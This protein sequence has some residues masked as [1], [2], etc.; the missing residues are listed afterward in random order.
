MSDVYVIK[1]GDSD[2]DV[3]I[4]SCV[5]QPAG[6]GY[7]HMCERYTRAETHVVRVASYPYHVCDRHTPMDVELWK[8]AM[9]R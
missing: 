7:C 9:T 5:R 3:P 4:W 1:D 8:E 2:A 6:I